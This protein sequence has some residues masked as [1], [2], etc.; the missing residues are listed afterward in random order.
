MAAAAL[1]LSLGLSGC[2]LPASVYAVAV[3]PN[4][5][6][7]R[8]EGS[9]IGYVTG[10]GTMQVKG[11]GISCSGEFSYTVYAQIGVGT[12]NCDT[13]ERV[14]VSF[15]AISST[16]GY[17]K[18]VSN[19]GRL[20]VFTFG[21][22]E[23]SADVYLAGLTGDFD[24]GK[25][26][27]IETPEP[28]TSSAGSGF[29]VTSDGYIVTND[30]VAGDC[31]RIEVTD[32]VGGAR[33]ARLIVRNK[34]L[35]LAVL[36]VAAEKRRFLSFRR[37]DPAL[38]EAVVAF[39]YPLSGVL[40]DEGVV[41]SG[42]VNA[43]NVS[44]ENNILQI[45]ASIQ[46]GNSGGPTVGLDGALVGVNVAKYLDSEATNVNLAVKGVAAARFVESSGVAI[47][48]VDR[49]PARSVEQIAALAK[50]AS[51]QVICDNK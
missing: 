20:I 48:W 43:L 18:G 23:S 17:G 4:G 11:P 6:A 24:A 5:D 13:G 31:E 8:L 37:E 9:A 35:D 40:S 49:G 14:K 34:G 36:K 15:K 22:N 30:H 7:L 44:G 33:A 2:T 42:E 16:V 41:T 50:E 47:R 26:G 28:K 46:P 21:M 32:A 51:V 45:S 19:E 10:N 27:R 38:G 39:G 3:S 25:S 12:L 29:F 1:L